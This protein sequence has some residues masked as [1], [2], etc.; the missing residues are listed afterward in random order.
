V[1]ATEGRLKEIA[2]P[3]DL[4]P[5]VAYGIAVVK[6]AKH[7]EQAQAFIDGL[8]DGAGAQALQDA[9]FRPPPEL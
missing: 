1:R 8:L 3:D 2:L 5:Q 7:P 6:G 9:G 4:Q